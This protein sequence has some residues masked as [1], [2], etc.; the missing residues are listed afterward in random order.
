MKKHRKSSGRNQRGAKS[1]SGPAET[2]S[3][4]QN[5]AETPHSDD[6]VESFGPWLRRQR[7]MREIDLREIAE[8]S[9]ISLR[10][11][12][13]LEEGRF[14]HLPAPVFTKGF[15]RQYAKY[16]GLDP[17]EV[18]NA[19]LDARRANEDED[20]D[21]PEIVPRKAARPSS[22][23]RYI[24]LALLLAAL[25]LLAVFLLSRWNGQE[26]GA[27]SGLVGGSDGS[28]ATEAATSEPAPP[29]T[30]TP[31]E[32]R[33]A[34]TTGPP[35]DEPAADADDADAASTSEGAASTASDPVDLSSL[36]LVLEFSGDCWVE[37]TVDGRRALAARKV[38]GESVRL[39]ADE[40]IELRFG[41]YTAVR[42]EV[43]GALWDLEPPRAGGNV[44]NVRIDLE[45]VRARAA[46]GTT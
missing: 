25:L 37:A 34:A 13:D 46:Q 30:G 35:V 20:E 38:Q 4:P 33:T 1:Q 3:A 24:A 36:D 26:G 10:Y 29:A 18:V 17:E 11:L 23:G 28:T 45:T 41:D 44:S 12:Q 6:G 2:P 16:V 9:K 19:F 39:A 40:W 21:G 42:V 27:F 32:P 43:N 8:T 7:E 31:G 14:E 15:L 22:G 5:Q